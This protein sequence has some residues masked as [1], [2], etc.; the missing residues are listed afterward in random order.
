MEQI[1][2]NELEALS[3]GYLEKTTEEVFPSWMETLGIFTPE[4][5]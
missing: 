5:K 4:V 1:L 2:E 3:V